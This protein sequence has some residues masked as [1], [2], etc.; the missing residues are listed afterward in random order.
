MSDEIQKWIAKF[1]Q[2]PG[3]IAKNYEGKEPN[4]LI[5]IFIPRNLKTFTGERKGTE[6]AITIFTLLVTDTFESSYW[7]GE[8]DL[9]YAEWED[10]LNSS[11]ASNWN[12]LYTWVMN[13]SKRY[14]NIQRK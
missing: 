3:I 13:L 12:D 9:I 1:N 5:E 7:D 14:Q 11:Y 2:I 4:Y 10:H 8:N 6:G